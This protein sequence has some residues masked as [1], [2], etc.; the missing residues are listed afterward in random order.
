MTPATRNNDSAVAVADAFDDTG[1]G[2]PTA[3]R[4]AALA[5]CWRQPDDDLQA[6]LAAETDTTVDAQSLRAEY[7]RLFVGPGPSQ[8]PPYESVYRDG[9]RDADLGPVYGPSTQAVARWYSEYGLQPAASE[10]APPDHLATEL[11]FAAYLREHEGAETLEQ[12]LT[13][14]P[15]NWIESFARRVRDADPKPFY[16]T[17]LNVTVDTLARADT[18]P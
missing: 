15:R 2:P 5:A 3:A 6:A 9:E 14:H 8:S 17:L 7:T 10:S 18:P 16:R 1:D 11:E 12:F 4:F 13:E